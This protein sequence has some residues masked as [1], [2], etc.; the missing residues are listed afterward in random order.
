M[1][2]ITTKTQFKEL[3]KKCKNTKIIEEVLIVNLNYEMDDVINLANMA[4]INKLYKLE[5]NISNTNDIY[6]HI[7]NNVKITVSKRG[8]DL[9]IDFKNKEK[10]STKTFKMRYSGD[11]NIVLPDDF[12]VKSM[13]LERVKINK[14]PNNVKVIEYLDIIGTDIDYIPDYTY[15]S[16]LYNKDNQYNKIRNVDG[17]IFN[18][19]N[20]YSILKNE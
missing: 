17:Y 2:I 3:Y 20:G 10:L 15:L 13:D 5:I 18:H 9:L 4:N 16:T 19:N 8:N 7:Y 14:F 12:T 11:Y 1:I 6:D